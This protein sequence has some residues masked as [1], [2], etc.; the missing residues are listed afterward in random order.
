MS[1]RA[2]LGV[3]AVVLLAQLILIHVR[4]TC[5]ATFSW[6]VVF[7]PAWLAL[8]GFFVSLMYSVITARKAPHVSAWSYVS[9]F[10]VWAAVLV[11]TILLTIH[12]DGQSDCRSRR[13]SGYGGP[14]GVIGLDDGSAAEAGEVLDGGRGGGDGRGGFD[15]RDD[16]PLSAGYV[17]IPAYVIVLVAF[18]WFFFWP[19]GGGKWDGG[20]RG[21]ST[22]D[23]RGR[24]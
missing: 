18:I 5:T 6:G 14:R 9:D 4:V 7:I 19:Y 23:V 16:D 13:G 11:L 10:V 3:S 17:F 15:G 1:W 21:T 22:S 12:L 8:A 20:G 24:A 2:I